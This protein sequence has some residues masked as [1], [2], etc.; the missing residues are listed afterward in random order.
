MKILFVIVAMVLLAGVFVSRRMRPKG[1]FCQ[2]CAMPMD[3]PGLFG[4]EAN[5][6]PSADYCTYCYQKGA[7]TEP[8]ITREQMIDKCVKHLAGRKIMPEEKARRLMTRYLPRLKR[9]K[10]S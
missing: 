2:S 9:W 4:T 6:A 7:F 8:G 10:A 3:K 5:G 1:P